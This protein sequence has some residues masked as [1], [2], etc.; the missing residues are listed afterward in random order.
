MRYM[1]LAQPWLN[2]EL[3]SSGRLPMHALAHPDRLLLDGT[4]DFQLLESPEAEPSGQWRKI[5]VPGAWTMQQTGD[6][7]QYTNIQ[8]P[9][10]QSPPEVPAANPTGVY[11]RNFEVPNG[12]AGRRIVLQVGAA[13]SVLLVRLNGKQLGFSK[14]SHLAAE[15]ELSGL[16]NAGQNELS[17]SVVKF[18]DASFVEDQDQWWHGGLT[19]SV[20]L[21]STPNTYL[22]DVKSVADFDPST[23]EGSL[24]LTIEVASTGAQIPAGYRVRALLVGRVEAEAAVP[25]HR[26]RELRSAP[27]SQPGAQ[28]HGFDLPSAYYLTAA[29]AD[30]GGPV[31]EAI[32]A[33]HAAT[34][35]NPGLVEFSLQ[36]GQVEPWS[37]ETPKLYPLLVQLIDPTGEVVEVSQFDVGFRRVEIQGRDLLVNGRRIWIQGINRHDFDPHAGRTVSREQ[38][39]N[40]LAQLKRFNINAIR[41]AHY[42]N[43]PMFLELTDRYGFY[44]VDEANI[45]SH[46]WA[47][48][49]CDNPRYL[50]AFVD[51]V[52]RMMLRDKNHPSVIIWSLGN[53][54]GSGVNHDAAAGWAR[55]YDPHRPLHYEGAINS[56]WHR[57]HHQT[58]IVAP[59]YPPIEAIVAYAQHPAADRP[60]IM[61][62]YQH[63]MGN[64]NGSLDDY[65]RAIKSTPGLQGG[66][67]WE[68][69]DHGLDPD[70]DGR[71]RYGG[72][73]GDTPNDGNFCI[74]GLLF[75]DGT[76]HPAMYELRR[77]FSP[78]EI[79]SSAA[80]L[81]NG[82]LCIRNEQHFADLSGFAFNARL[83]GIHDDGDESTLSVAAGPG[84]TAD[85]VLPSAWTEALGQKQTIGLRLI[86]ATAEELPWAA[87]G[88]EIA[89][90][91]LTIRKP[92]SALPS[93]TPG[94]ELT[95]DSEGLV[96]HRHFAVGP[97]L[98]FWRAQ[99]DND[100]LR[101]GGGLLGNSGLDNVS[102]RLQS[103][104]WTTERSAAT[105]TSSYL[106]STGI[107]IQHV[108]KV[109][110]VA[111]GGLVFEETVAI[112]ERLEDLPRVGFVLELIPGFEKLD[113]LGDG[114][115]ESYPDRR[116]SAM[117]GRWKASVAEL[118]VPYIKPQENGGRGGVSELNLDN[119]QTRLQLLFDRG[120]QFSAAHV[121]IEDLAQTR[122]NWELPDRPETFVYLDVAHRGLGTASVGP[123]ALPQFRLRSGTYTWSWSI[124]SAPRSN[125]ADS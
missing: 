37:A 55:G 67:V 60:L 28:R 105:I 57:G 89:E 71:Y 56:D 115:H 117:H 85:V 1:P 92:I 97:R 58:D 88:S 59:M 31:N 53:E 123:D 100:R 110:S 112:P 8:M 104:E 22:R 91:Q 35:Q 43:D 40:Q 87:A 95:L 118:Q 50:Y 72:D 64:S 63:A 49:I 39:Q 73:F 114:P 98:N 106:S 111:S 29:G 122:H 45:E 124:G 96:Q 81:Q 26:S 121:R 119:G 62:E 54:S 51:R 94:G 93:G 101:F 15:F 38:L 18:S 78:V 102:R 42:P 84:E 80:Q 66:F 32:E 41:T 125:S 3:V 109:R 86:I 61:C 23:G 14:D 103:I 44:V 47:R 75:P 46:D 24:D 2:P 17:L 4:W 27:D 120:M 10:P 36:T 12:W 7:P 9:F 6:L 82:I 30:L 21:Y 52:S 65:W 25:P 76:P 48:S 99:T 90:L 16:L 108:Q 68:L 13:E 70:S 79:V 116:S 107:S 34:W 74:D 11:R 20:F 19:R 33:Y 77:I 69:W 5:N 83:V 113:W